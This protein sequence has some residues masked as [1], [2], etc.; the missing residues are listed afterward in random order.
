MPPI[1]PE[2]LDELLKDYQKPE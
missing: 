1:R 2:L